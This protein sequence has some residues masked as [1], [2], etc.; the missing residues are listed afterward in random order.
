M[1]PHIIRHLRPAMISIRAD[2]LRSAAETMVMMTGERMSSA[3]AQ[4]PPNLS[5]MGKYE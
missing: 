4:D 5:D 2:R 1:H 3:L